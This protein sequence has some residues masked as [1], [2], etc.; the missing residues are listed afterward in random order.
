MKLESIYEQIYALRQYGKVYGYADFE[1]A[2][3]LMSK[4]ADT[5]EQYYAIGT[6][7]ECRAAVE[8]QR[9]KKP[10]ADGNDRYR[11][12]IDIFVCPKCG[13]SVEELDPDCQ[14]WRMK[15]C[16]NCGQAISWE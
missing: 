3:E 15:F 16:A 14:S 8:K 9:A 11:T 5:I 6:P 4:A 12:E 2:V 10:E 1:Y 13:A 7:D